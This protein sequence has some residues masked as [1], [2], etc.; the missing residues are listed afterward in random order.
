MGKVKNYRRGYKMQITH[1]QTFQ[2]KQKINS[3]RTSKAPLS[4]MSVSINNEYNKKPLNSISN[5]V[6]FKGFSFKPVCVE[7][8]NNLIVHDVTEILGLAKKHLGVSAEKLFKDVSDS[9]SPL[10]KNMVNISKDSKGKEVVSFNEKTVPRLILDGILYPFTT[11]P[12]DMLN[13]A[14]GFLKKIKP[15]EKWADGVYNTPALEKM[16]Q[17]SMINNKIDSL[18]GLFETI[19]SNKANPELSDILF[20]KS[21]KMFDLKTGNYDTKHERSLNRIVSGTIPA[22]FLANDAYNL[23]MMSNKQKDE[24]LQGKDADKEAK[25]RFKQEVTRVGLTAYLQLITF[26]AIQKYINNS[27]TLV[28]LNT[29]VTALVIESISRIS[30]GKHITKLTPEKAKEINAKGSSNNNEPSPIKA[31]DTP[32]DNKQSTAFLT[33]NQKSKAF[34]PVTG[35]KGDAKTAEQKK[36]EPLL[37]FNTLMKAS[38]VVLVAGYALKGLRKSEK[39]DEYF[40]KFFKYFEDQYKKL[41]VIPDYTLPKEK[42]NEILTK[43][44]KN[45]FGELA[46]KYEQ[47]SKKNIEK[48][49]KLIFGEKDGIIHL[50]A[51]VK[52]NQPIVNFLITPFNSIYRAVKF[53]YALAES[54]RGFI[55]KNPP[56]PAKSMEELSSKALSE[57]IEKMEKL[58]NLSDDKFVDYVNDNILKQFNAQTIS[59]IPNNE[60]SN[61][62]KTATTA[63]TL[64]F[65]MTDNYNMVMLKSNGEDKEGAEEKFKGRFVQEMSRLFYQTL[66]IDLFNKT[67]VNQYNGSLMGMSWVTVVDTFIGEVLT[68]KSIGV[69]VSRHNKE[70]LIEMENKKENATGLLKGYYDFMAK[71]T[72]KKSLTEQKQA[73]EVKK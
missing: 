41:T 31:E 61:M 57:S 37:S 3:E 67:F 56:K 58:K 32:S 49:G 20:Q 38:A 54:V 73:K 34:G 24:S 21:A 59:K 10:V 2:V 1:N 8:T 69:P 25:I 55:W 62:A 47:I 45:G 66:L 68:R 35:F 7:K 6:S 16:R 63:A 28:M 9:D 48:D 18:R 50:G 51:K 29:A 43:L 65:L 15:L 23:A 17:N 40:I 70:E 52:K 71:L 14:V 60:L 27:S 53:P 19:Q 22:I 13:G 12:Q 36:Q 64:G 33:P 30:N 4:L 46:D 39:I 11:L 72:G 44:R 5:D 42:F 26:G